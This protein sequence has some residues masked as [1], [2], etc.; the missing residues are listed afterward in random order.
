MFLVDAKHAVVTNTPH[1]CRITPVILYFHSLRFVGMGKRI[2][3]TS[4][5]SK[6]VKANKEKVYHA[7]TD[8]KAFVIIIFKNIPIGV[9]PKDNE[10]GTEQSLEKLAAY[11]ENN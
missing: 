11:V 6:I 2:Y 9:D 7:F 1:G 3:S 4:K 5:N 10:A 8:Q